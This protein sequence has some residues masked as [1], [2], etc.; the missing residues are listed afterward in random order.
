MQ[1]VFF[2]K[3][4]CHVHT[5]CSRGHFSKKRRRIREVMINQGQESKGGSRRGEQAAGVQ[6]V[7]SLCPRFCGRGNVHEGSFL[8]SFR[9]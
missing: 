2:A 6:E 7:V 3:K 9:A 4:I 8:E 5:C 1:V